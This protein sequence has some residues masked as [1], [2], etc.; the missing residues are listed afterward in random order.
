MSQSAYLIQLSD[1]HLFSNSSGT[2]LGL[3]TADSLAAILDTLQHQFPPPDALLLTG[4]LAQEP[5]TQTYT[6]LAN[7]LKTFP[8]PVYWLPGNHDDPAAM[9]PALAQPPLRGDRLMSLGAWQGIL[10]NSQVEGQVHGALSETTLHWLDDQLSNCSD[11]P[12]FIA[13]H[14][15]PFRTGAPWLDSSR[16]QNPEALFGILDRHPQVKLVL[17]GHI[18]QS[19]MAERQ[20]VTYLGCPSTCIQFLPRAAKFTLEPIGPGFRQ[21]WLEADGTVRTQIQRVTIP[22]TLDFTSEGY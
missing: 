12:T 21:L 20:G 5:C 22:L 11:R 13:L 9:I 15:P 2:L 18:H 1:L 4:D 16:L 3:R 10:L 14:H 6:N 19:F 17:F 7:A 8:C